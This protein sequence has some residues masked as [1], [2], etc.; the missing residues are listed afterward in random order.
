MAGI[1]VEQ[2]SCT[3]SIA[4]LQ[5]CRKKY[6]SLNAT[7]PT[8]LWRRLARCVDAFTRASSSPGHSPVEP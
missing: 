8:D 6:S 1:L 4:G 2:A 5:V 3:V 7:S